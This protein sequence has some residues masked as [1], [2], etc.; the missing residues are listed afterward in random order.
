[1]RVAAI[2]GVIVL[3]V[4]LSLSLAPAT[5]PAAPVAPSPTTA[6]I[7]RNVSIYFSPNGGATAAVVAELDAA[8][9][10]IDVQAYSFTSAPIA[11]AVKDAH[12]RGVKVR[13][14]LDRSQRTARYSSATY[15]LN[16]GVPTFIDA[17]H[18]AA[19]NKVMLI[20]G[21]TIITG[22]FNFTKAAEESNAENLLIIREDASLSAAYADNFA[23]HLRHSERYEGIER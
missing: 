8:K 7:D 19:H 12:E 16:A 9:D 18:R 3:A 15:L 13:V 1:M 5:R 11:K 21:R 22:S 6:P 20:D 10:T 2:L 17:Q 14:I 23:E 4:G